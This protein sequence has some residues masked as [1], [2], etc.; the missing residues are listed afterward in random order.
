MRKSIQSIDLFK[1]I[2]SIIVILIHTYPFYEAMPDVGFISSNIIGRTVIPFY[3]LCA[4]YFLKQG[5][6]SKKTD[7]FKHYMK[8]L[9]QLYLIWSII[10][11]PAGLV[12]MQRNLSSDLIV[13]WPLVLV[14]ALVY[15]GT[16]FHLWYMAALIFSCFVAKK[17]CD[18]FSL[19]SLLIFSFITLLFGLSETYY[20]LFENSFLYGPLTTYFD[21]LITTKS[22]LTLGLFYVALGFY[23]A[24]SKQK[25]RTQYIYYV[26]FFFLLLFLEAQFVRS[27]G[28][29]IDYNFYFSSIPFTYYLFLWLLQ[30]PCRLPLNFRFLRELSTIIYFSHGIF[31]ELIPYFL[32]YNFKYLFDIGAFRF[33]SV[34]LCTLLF[35]IIVHRFFKKLY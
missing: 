34:L 28:W 15:A 8:R 7:Y 19:K 22:G 5:I 17:W 18:H 29:A 27:Q 11:L 12:F 9:I 26:L 16:Y 14:V 20:G 33:S 6:T 2:G 1:F 24:S 31:L 35:S 32:P 10:C 23:I 4:G 21:L 13:F 3:F 25:K 30:T